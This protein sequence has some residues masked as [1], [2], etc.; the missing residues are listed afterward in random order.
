Q[1][2]SRDH[3][4]HVME[5]TGRSSR[6]G[7]VATAFMAVPLGVSPWAGGNDPELY[8]GSARSGAILDT[9]EGDQ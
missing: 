2:P 3:V 7:A 4:Q 9:V 6:M 1:Q 8:R 5:S